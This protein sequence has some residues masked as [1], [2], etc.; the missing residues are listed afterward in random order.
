[1]DYQSRLSTWQ[2]ALSPLK[3]HALL[4]SNLTNVRYATGF[5]GT[6][7]MIVVMPDEALFI[8]DF[9]Y[10]TQATQ[11]VPDIYQVI[12]GEVG[13]WQQACDLL[14]EKLKRRRNVRIGIEGEHVSVAQF[15]E[16][17]EK[18]NPLEPFSTVKVIENSRLRKEADELKIIRR[19]VKV[20][21]EVFE[22]ICGYLKPGLTEI[23]VA[24]EI[25]RAMKARGASGVSFDTIVAS[26][27]RSALPHGVASKK[28]LGKNDIVTIDMGAIVD[29]YCSDMTRTLCLGKATR[30]QKDI[31]E[32]VYR[33]QTEAA[34]QLRP[35]LD[36]VAA[37]KIARDIIEFSGCGA[38]FGHGLGHGV[39]LNIHESPRLS[40]LGKGNLEAGMVVTCEPGVYIEGVGGVRIEDMLLITKSGADILTQSPK[41]ATILEL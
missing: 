19:A 29:G 13:L 16:L 39:G 32:L 36:C 27:H 15:D 30:R 18:L 5:T 23:E 35:G 34:A 37:D 31:Y 3:C 28:K 11:Q 8:T 12:I 10:Q 21:D 40:R 7:G 4:I 9:R 33:A 2:S 14:K 6:S 25:E 24:N 1:M 26:G 20:A 17:K 38:H 22:Y 41:P